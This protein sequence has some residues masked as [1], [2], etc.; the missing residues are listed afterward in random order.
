[1]SQFRPPKQESLT[2]KET[3]TS[4]AKWQSN[5]LFH[6]S[7]NNEFAPFL[8]TEWKKKSETNRG[9]EDGPS[10]VEIE[11]RKTAVQKNIILERML[12]LIAQFIPSLLRH[13]IIK[14][15]TSLNWIWKRIRKYCSFSQS[16][17]N[18]LK[19]HFIKREVDERYETLYQRIVAHLEDNLLTVDS[20]LTHDGEKPTE[21]EEIS[22]TTER[23]A[24]L[25]W[26]KII[27]ERLPPYIATVYAH[28]LQ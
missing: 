22:P 5:L 12:A 10:S 7:L 8:D 20:D 11:V 2:E 14:K 3:I 4:F 16:E 19:L 27:D 24:V 9:L 15:A 17:T 28:D 23:L 18:F 26:L 1:M 21:D 25:W 6:L 13:D